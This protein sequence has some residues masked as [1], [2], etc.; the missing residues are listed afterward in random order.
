MSRSLHSVSRICKFSGATLS[1]V[2]LA[3]FA[4]PSPASAAVPVGPPTLSGGVDGQVYATLVV[5]DTVFV[6][7]SF[8][9]A[10]VRGGGSVTRG[11]VA[12]FNRTTG[13]LI[14][15][16]SANANATV[17][18]LATDGSSLYIGG[19]FTSIGGTNQRWLVKASL[20]NG[21]ID[22]QFRAQLNQRVFGLQAA[23]GA[24]YAGGNFTT[25]SG[26]SQRYLAKLDA[27][28]GA[29]DTAFT[30]STDGP[31]NA[32]ALSPDGSRLAVGGDFTQISGQSR[33][34]M[35]LVDPGTGASTDN[36]FTGSVQPMLSLAY[37]SDGSRLYGGSG[38]VNNLAASWNPANGGRGWHIR[39]GG[40]VQ[41]IGYAD[42]VVYVGFHDNFEGNPHT[43]LLAVDADS[44]A[45]SASF[46]PSFDHYMGIRSI[47]ASD[48]GLIVGG[49]FTVVDG[50]W[51]HGW[52]RWPAQ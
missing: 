47:S 34:G 3:L 16:W 38:D 41:A 10:Q 35:G 12:A 31:V 50:V 15:T 11:D 20:A 49:Q 52:A 48:Q 25:A 5:G 19:A 28:T 7:G 30:G 27:T 26:A 17:R 43:K 39:V 45:I 37:S 23:G 40:D 32:L 33:E 24:V 18:A 46:R 4:V 8:T 13:A 6:G 36:A 29:R 44:G 1:V 2:A 22:T 51:A 9:H 14:T 42:G 21:A